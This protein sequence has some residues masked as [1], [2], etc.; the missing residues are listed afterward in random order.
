MPETT[1]RILAQLY[2]DNPASG[3]RDFDDL[4]KFGLRESG[5]RVT[6]K[7][8]ILFARLELEEVLKQVEEIQK[9]QT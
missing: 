2:P 6:P 7:P 1:D 9:A 3:V 5:V 8:E 4:D